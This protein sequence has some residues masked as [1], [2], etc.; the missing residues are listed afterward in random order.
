[1]KTAQKEHL[2][3][4]DSNRHHRFALSNISYIICENYLC[5]IH[6]FHGDHV[7]CSISLCKIEEM[8]KETFF[9]KINRHILLNLKQVVMVECKGRKRF[10]LLKNGERLP[11]ADR[12][13]KDFKSIYY[14]DTLAEINDTFAENN[15]TFT[16]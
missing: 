1:M 6:R 15:D 4:R 8:L 14:S 2:V 10:A 11:I 7:T 9:Y 12:R 13:W 5:T 16:K 3:L